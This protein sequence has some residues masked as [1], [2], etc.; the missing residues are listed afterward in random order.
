MPLACCGVLAKESPTM[1][2]FLV[3]LLPV[4][5]LSAAPLDQR[6]GARQEEAI[7]GVAIETLGRSAVG[8]E[9]D[10]LV[11]VRVTIEP[12]ASVPASDG[13]GAAVILLE[14]GRVGVE[15]EGAA[16]GANLTLAGGNEKAPLTPGSERILA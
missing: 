11:L 15:L 4:L 13:L 7:P 3:V 5:A 9:G 2:R 6:V 14:A 10:E 16:G 8:E 1:R 12:A